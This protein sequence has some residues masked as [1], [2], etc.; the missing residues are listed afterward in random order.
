MG[1][2]PASRRCTTKA[3]AYCSE[4]FVGSQGKMRV[5]K[6][7][8]NL[9]RLSKNGP[10]RDTSGD[11]STNSPITTGNPEPRLITF[12]RHCK[13]SLSQA[14]PARLCSNHE[15][16]CGG[17][18]GR[19]RVIIPDMPNGPPKRLR[20]CWPVRHYG[21]KVALGS[22][23]AH[24]FAANEL[25]ECGS[26]LHPQKPSSR[27]VPSG[28]DTLRAVVAYKPLPGRG[29]HEQA[30]RVNPDFSA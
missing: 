12:C 21:S 30:D 4:W 3:K 15:R 23:S 18:K 1:D 2:A 22:C 19:T 29:H 11:L 6:R 25:A 8:W 13:Q 5:Y 9:A 26:R 17:H 24:G 16:M 7:R 20:P 10:R 27:R 14:D 28:L